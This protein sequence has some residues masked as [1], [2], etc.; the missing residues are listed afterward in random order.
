MK[1]LAWEDYIAALGTSE[2]SE[3]FNSLLA[4]IGERP[5]ISEDPAE[6]NDPLRHTT[7]YKFIEHGLEIGFRRGQLNH[8][9]FFLVPNQGYAASKVQL[10]ANV[11]SGWNKG[12]VSSRL[13]NPNLSAEGKHDPLLGY[14]NSWDKYEQ[15]DHAI[16]I[17]Y[18]PKGNVVLVSLMLAQV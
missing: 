2:R 4:S 18:G 6:Y 7:Y 8:M 14:M 5:V 16:R 11:D 10:V 13:G 15:K 12:A 9:H 1:H 17:E 3:P